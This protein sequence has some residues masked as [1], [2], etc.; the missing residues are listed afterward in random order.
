M[1]LND[2][3]KK[4]ETFV[5][6]GMVFLSTTNNYKTIYGEESSPDIIVDLMVESLIDVILLSLGTFI[7]LIRL[8]YA[9]ALKLSFLLNV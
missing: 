1:E 5:V 3:M 2:L 4:M 9:T 7:V 6:S 8:S